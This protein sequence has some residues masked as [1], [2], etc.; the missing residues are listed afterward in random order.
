MLKS[1]KKR[2]T[3]TAYDNKLRLIRKCV[4]VFEIW[5]DRALFAF[6]CARF[7]FLGAVFFV[8]ISLVYHILPDLQYGILCE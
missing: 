2:N 8:T 3:S 6:V 4:S 5:R 1:A 7:V